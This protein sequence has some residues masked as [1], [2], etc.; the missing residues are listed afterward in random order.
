MT[1]KDFLAQAR[2]LA[3]NSTEVA[4]RSAVSRAYYGAFHEARDLVE[5]LGFAVPPDANAYRYLYYR[6]S[7]AGYPQVNAAG[8]SLNALRR[9]RTWADYLL[10]HL[11][12]PRIA[13]AAVSMAE[14]IIQTLDAA[15]AEPIRTQITDAM[16]VY[17]R[18]VLKTVTWRP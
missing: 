4:W 10:R 12:P 16:K 11:P 2:M 5:S 8:Q 6:L 1:G 3:A 9:Q 14:Q 15:I 7:N 13:Q 17:E 18:D